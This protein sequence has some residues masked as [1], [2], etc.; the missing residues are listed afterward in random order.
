L[1]SQE[2][3]EKVKTPNETKKSKL[4]KQPRDVF[5]TNFIVNLSNP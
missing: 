4:T 1:K 5:I 3:T 2:G